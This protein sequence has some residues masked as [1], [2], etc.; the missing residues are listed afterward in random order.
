MPLT[1]ISPFLND[2]LQRGT[3]V[4]DEFRIATRDLASWMALTVTSCFKAPRTYWLDD[5]SYY[6]KDENDTYST[7]VNVTQN[8]RVV[9]FS[10]A[11]IN[12]PPTADTQCVKEICKFICTRLE[13]T[14]FTAKL[15]DLILEE[16]KPLRT[17]AD[18]FYRRSAHLFAWS[19]GTVYDTHTRKLRKCTPED[20]VYKTTGYPYQEAT[21]EDI[22]TAEKFLSSLVQQQREEC[23]LSLL[24]SMYFNPTWK[25]DAIGNGSGVVDTVVL[26]G[27]G[28][29]GKSLLLHVM[30]AMLG[31]G[32]L[33]RYRFHQ[34]GD[35]NSALTV[36]DCTRMPYLDGSNL[37][38]VKYTVVIPFPFTFTDSGEKRSIASLYRTLVTPNMLAAMHHIA[39]RAG[40]RH[41]F[42]ILRGNVTWLDTIDALR[43]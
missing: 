39:M 30:R 19:C 13:E 37:D 24:G 20:C 10:S 34:R 26:L 5:G 29:N 1:S 8:S 21:V 43:V 40:E 14:S 27:K 28:S 18:E 42:D 4:N 38:N 41:N 31:S 17:S 2:L 35:A 6:T 12:Y 15:E 23:L 22:A 33:D 25:S 7:Q 16:I 36:L 11:L 3:L 32:N 9:F